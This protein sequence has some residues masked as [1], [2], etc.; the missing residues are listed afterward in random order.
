MLLS[1]SGGSCEKMQTL[2]LVPAQSGAVISV[3][4]ASLCNRKE[5]G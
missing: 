1:S 2:A 5:K 4:G 3:P